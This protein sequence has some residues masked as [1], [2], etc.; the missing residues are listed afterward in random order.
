MAA[1]APAKAGAI[2]RGFKDT[3]KRVLR[4]D[5]VWGKQNGDEFRYRVYHRVLDRLSNLT[6][7]LVNRLSTDTE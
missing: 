6:Y 1:A 4:R 3:T 2:A 5:M 7:D